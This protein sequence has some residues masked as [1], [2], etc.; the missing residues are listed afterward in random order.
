MKHPALTLFEL[1]ERLSQ[2]TRA[3]LRETGG[4]HG[5]QPV[6]VQ[7]LFYLSQANRYSNTPQALAD[8]LGLTRGTVSQTLILLA[9]RK[10]VVRQ[11]DARD[12]RVVRL[13]L[14]EQGAQ[15]LSGLKVAQAWRDAVAEVTPARLGSTK[16]VLSQVLGRVI[17][18]GGRRSFGV[19]ASCRHLERMGPRSY[20]CG[21]T[22][23]RLASRE[24]R[25]ICR[26]HAPFERGGG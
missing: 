4:E 20:A 7:V 10:L 19:C 13:A 8:Y 1:V 17:E 14:S 25:Q 5:L 9:R 26:E 12:G 15:V 2:L 21:L 11:A 24:T 23:E 6:H 18:R 3:G 16:L 22:R